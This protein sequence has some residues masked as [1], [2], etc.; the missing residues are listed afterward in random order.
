VSAGPRLWA[1][2]DDDILPIGGAVA[3]KRK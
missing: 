3:K 1:R 2:G